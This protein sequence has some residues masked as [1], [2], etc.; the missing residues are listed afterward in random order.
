[1]TPLNDPVPTPSLT[2]SRMGPVCALSP[3]SSDPVPPVPPPTGTGSLR[4]GV[5]TP[6]QIR[7]DGVL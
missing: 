7:R 1:M 4:D 3:S 6:S 5:T 2:P